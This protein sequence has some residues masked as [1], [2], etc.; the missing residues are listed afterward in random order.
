MLSHVTQDEL[1]KFGNL[2]LRLLKPND[3]PAFLDAYRESY[4]SI[5]SYMVVSS[6]EEMNSIVH[7][8]REYMKDLKRDNLDFFGLFENN[9]LLAIGLYF[10][11]SYSENG[12]QIVLWVR[13]SEANR[14]L[15]TF[16]LKRLTKFAFDVKHCRF[17]ELV[18]DNGNSASKAIAEKVGYELMD[19]VEKETQGLLGTGIYCRYM[20]FDTQIESLVS[21]FRRQPLDLIDHP[22]YEDKY[23]ELLND[24]EVNRIFSWGRKTL[25]PRVFESQVLGV[26]NRK[27]RLEYLWFK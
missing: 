16:F 18:I 24:D 9:R 20:I 3:F 1:A 14:K 27:P 2:E 8:Q 21:E 12:C 26:P 10:P 17:I 4:E 5:A 23:R 15:G 7:L 13:K 19:K 25:N 6:P 22:G 11:L